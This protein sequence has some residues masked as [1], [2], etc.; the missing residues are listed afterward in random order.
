[1]K[2]TKQE[3]QGDSG[4]Y[5]VAQKIT[6]ELCWIFR[7]QPR[8]DYGIDAIVEIVE[9]EETKGQL[10]ALQI[11]S[12]SSWL[13]E[14]NLNYIIFRSNKEHLSYW[15][16]YPIPLIIVLHD[17]K[18]NN[19]YWQIVNEQTIIETE[20]GFKVEIPFNQVIDKKQKN[21]LK[22]YCDYPISSNS[23]SIYSMDDLSHFNAKRYKALVL[24]NHKMS[25]GEIVQIVK[26][27]TDSLIK[28]EYYR[29]KLVE[30]CWK[31]KPANIVWL[32]VYPSLEDI[33]NDNWICRTEWID[34]N[35]KK[36]FQPLKMNGMAIG[37]DLSI[38]WSS[39]YEEFSNYYKNNLISKEEFLNTVM[40][41]LTATKNIIEGIRQ[42]STQ[43]FNNRISENNFL[44]QM[45][46][47]ESKISELYKIAS[48]VCGTPLECKDFSDKFQSLMTTASNIVLPFSEKGLETWEKKNRECLLKL[49]IEDYVNRLPKLSYEY[50]KLQ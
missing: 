16:E 8:R 2:V 39:Y 32:F 26:S 20:K 42:L 15:K 44:N 43:Y 31:G 14:Q 6:D 50:E 19:A 47:Y 21:N 18:T 17:P 3:Q 10:L 36:E 13:K 5:N 34:P 11:K 22:K 35:L 30:T 37:E 33:K 7:D 29:N 38:D 40:P 12:G 45:E 1:M 28:R 49:Y 23:F 46:K 9:N 48:S 41:I 4:L 24:L 25:K 27:I